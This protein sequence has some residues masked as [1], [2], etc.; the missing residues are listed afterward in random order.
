MGL[1]LAFSPRAALDLEEIGDYIA[2]DN[3]SRAVSFMREIKQHCRSLA[4]RPAAFPV[5]EDLAAGIRM[6]VHGNYLIFFRVLEKTVR[7]ERVIHG[8]RNLSS[9]GLEPQD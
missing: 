6:A 9:A 3:P 2:L 5:R 1:K 4:R 7:E 8:A